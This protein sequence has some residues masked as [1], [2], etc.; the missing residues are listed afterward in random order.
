MQL[1]VDDPWLEP[2]EGDLEGRFNYYKARRESIEK[3][4]KSLRSFAASYNDLGFNYDKK[5]GQWVYKEWAPEALSLT[6]IGSF[7]NWE[8]G[9]SMMKAET[10]VW[11]VSIPK[12]I[13]F[14]HET[15]V[16]VRITG[17]D[18]K[19]L[20][21][22]PAFIEHAIQNAETY[23]FTGRIW[24]PEK[25]FRW[26]DGKFNLTQ[27]KQPIIYEAHV[28]LAQEEERVG[29][30][31]EFASNVLPRIK[32]LG[33]NC[34]QLMAVKE[35]PYYGSF[36]YHVSNFFAPSSRFG[37]P[38]DLKYLINEAHKLGM[39]VIMDAV[40][41]HAVKNISEGL[42]QFDGSEY[43]YF[44]EGGKGYHTSWDSKLF[45]YGK[46]EVLQFLLSSVRYWIEE[47]H[48]DGFRFD[49]VTSMLYEH[50]GDYVSFDH[51][52]KYFKHQID[53]DAIL[54]LQLAN[55]LIHEIKPGAITIAEDMSGMPGMCR[56]VEDGGIG[57][58]Y[59]LGMGIPDYWIKLL[60]HRKDEDWNIYEIWDVLTNRRYKEK[61]VAYS[62]SHDQALVGDKTLAFWLMDKEM[63][64]HM[65]VNDNHI[66]IDRGIAL[67]KMI[68]LI[69]ATLGGEAYLN[70]IGNEFGHPEWVDFPRE[71]NG[72]SYKYAKR[73]WSLVDDESLK[74]GFINEFEKEMI[75]V[76]RAYD[77]LSALPAQQLNMDEV[78]KV[79][80]F[81]RNNLLFLFNF[82]PSDSIPDYA[83]YVPQ[84]GSYKAIL[85]S[86]AAQFG[87]H[88]R[89]DLSTKYIASELPAGGY[90][91]KVYLT[92]RTAMVLE[93][94]D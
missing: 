22:L 10:G 32:A 50:H 14:G 28:G 39:A 64:W 69:T 65:S 82:H 24:S 9:L 89:I 30:F 46:E 44:H 49:G 90:E 58:D 56:K 92:N 52:D 37:T 63:Y 75:R 4:F 59:R 8:K 33:F 13:N 45:N 3:K 62:E 23:D 91:L 1:I 43:Q 51:Y 47:F 34:I 72:W 18:G 71:G 81:E 66:A 93:K 83:F 67:L 17:K 6:L 57:F 7:D 21:R 60:K 53:E 79:I 86:D 87:G 84:K 38:D 94:T 35:H 5:N 12:A 42:N 25:P 29:T 48:F 76:L 2:Y 68:R 11:E 40:Y 31:R 36:G 54:F 15:D 80:I 77:V 74:Y 78:N 55:E 16:K 26:S 85:I 41:S 73:Q 27:I 61:T 88:E 20:D 19:T 70:F